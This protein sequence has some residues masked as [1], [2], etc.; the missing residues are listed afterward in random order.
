MCSLQSN[1]ILLTAVGSACKVFLKFKLN[2]TRNPGMWLFAQEKFIPI[3]IFQKPYPTKP[4]DTFN[5]GL[6]YPKSAGHLEK[7]DWIE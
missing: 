6:R 7:S 5:Q 1:F 4:L 2:G 3:N